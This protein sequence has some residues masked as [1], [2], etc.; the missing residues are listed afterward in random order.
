MESAPTFIASSG[1]EIIIMHYLEKYEKKLLE[2]IRMDLQLHFFWSFSLTIL[3]VF[4][5]PFI[6]SGLIITILKEILDVAAK[7][8]WSW[9]DVIWGICGF[10]AGLYFLYAAG[11]WK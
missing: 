1:H 4:W 7:K 2:I 10:I 6:A 9:G 11:Y 8:G 3:A 5:K